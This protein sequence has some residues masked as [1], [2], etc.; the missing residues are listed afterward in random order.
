M[1][2]QEWTLQIT[3]EYDMDDKTNLFKR[4]E[5]RNPAGKLVFSVIEDLQSRSDDRYSTDVYDQAEYERYEELSKA[6][7]IKFQELET[8]RIPY[9]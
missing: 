7:L 1:E 6:G 9:Y 2:P 3:T 4:T 5:Y 8:E